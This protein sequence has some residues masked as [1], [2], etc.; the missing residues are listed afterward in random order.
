MTKISGSAPASANAFAVSYSQLVP[1]NTGR[2]TL[3]VSVSTAGAAVLRM[4]LMKF[5]TGRSGAGMLQG[6]TGSSRS[7]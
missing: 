4:P 1:G 5:S 7:S 2:S 6:Y 3:G